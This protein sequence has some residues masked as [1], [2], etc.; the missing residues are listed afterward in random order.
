[1]FLHGPTG[2]DRSLIDASHKSILRYP[3]KKSTFQLIMAIQFVTG[4]DNQMFV[5]TLMLL[6]SFANAGAAG[7]IKVCDFGFTPGQQNFLKTRD[8]LLVAH[9]PIPESHRH[10]WFH[11]AA[12]VD[13][14]P[15]NVDA[16]VWLDADM[17]V[18]GDPRSEIEALVA[19]MR[20][21]GAVIAACGDDVGD[22]DTFCRLGETQGRGIAPFVRIL[23]QLGVKQHHPYIN[24]GIFVATTRQWLSEWKNATFKVE[25]HFLFEQNAFN[26]LA[27]RTP[28][29]IHILDRRRW[30][31]HGSD[32]DRIKMDAAL[33]SLRCDDQAVMV[34]HATSPH[35]RHGH[36]VEVILDVGGKRIRHMIRVLED[37]RLQ[38]HQRA[39]LEQFL[40]LH[41]AELAKYL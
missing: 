35:R 5:Q 19:E 18:T 23:H 17:L 7:A 21:S 32:F 36:M 2:F 27:W 16:V 29:R 6:Q 12:L 37:S 15:R 40:R 30:N 31:L 24:I 14:L 22:L 25:P 11:K 39:L 3:E 26:A 34:V 28:E 20:R 38:A 8:Q 9:P 1:M 41:G 10:P 33:G 4:A 13:F